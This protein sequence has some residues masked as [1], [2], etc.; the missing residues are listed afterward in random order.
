MGV[1]TGANRFLF[2]DCSRPEP[3]LA[4]SASKIF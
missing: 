2:G 3:L 4:F 1:I